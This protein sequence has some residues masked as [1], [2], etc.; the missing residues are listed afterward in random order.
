MRAIHSYLVA[1]TLAG[2]MGMASYFAQAQQ[3]GD[4]PRSSGTSNQ[5]TQAEEDKSSPVVAS[6]TYRAEKLK[7][8][9]VRNPEGEELG[10]IEDLVLDME[11]HRLRYAALSYGGFL[12]VGDKLFAIP[13]EALRLKHEGDKSYFIADIDKETLKHAP[14]FS[15]NAWP[16]FGDPAW[17]AGMEK[18]YGRYQTIAGTVESATGGTLTLADESGKK[19]EFNI[20]P[21]VQI[22]HGG[23][24][25][26]L[27]DLRKGQQVKVTTTQRDGKRVA[28]QVQAEVKRF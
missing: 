5:A 21:N 12:G 11:S 15:K 7:G 16:D 27:D 26:K 13:I 3:S 9:K 2:V 19:H 28:S 18:H 14:G 10:A 17:V 24:P 25:A 22:V 6:K 4:T 1:V 20:G 23:A 8:M